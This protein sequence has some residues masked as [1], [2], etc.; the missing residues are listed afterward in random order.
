MKC[1][2][3][4]EGRNAESL[5]VKCLLYAR[6]ASYGLIDS[7]YIASGCIKSTVEQLARYMVGWRGYF[8]FY[9][10]PEVLVFL[11]RKIWLRL[12]CALWWQWKS[13]TYGTAA[14]GVEDE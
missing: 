1:N 7:I 2:R 8:D 13:H 9:E 14:P 5:L 10:T 4:R 11:T 3:S 12:R 6:A